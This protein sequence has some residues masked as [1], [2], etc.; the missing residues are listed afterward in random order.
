MDE[1][2]DPEMKKLREMFE[3]LDSDQDQGFDLSWLKNRAFLRF[4]R[5]LCSFF[6]VQDLFPAFS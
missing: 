3:I 5:V 4:A 2:R 6:E 1:G